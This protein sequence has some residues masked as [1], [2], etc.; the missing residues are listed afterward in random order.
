MNEPLR[1]RAA[2][3][4]T[5]TTPRELLEGKS[6]PVKGCGQ[7]IR[8]ELGSPSSHV[9]PRSFSEGIR[10]NTI[11]QPVLVSSSS[12]AA[13]SR[14]TPSAGREGQARSTDERT[15]REAPLRHGPPPLGNEES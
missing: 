3:A 5:E 1:R 7:P 9:P 12:A 4:G 2:E 11:V 15:P 8:T 6:C 13:R 10:A 14:R